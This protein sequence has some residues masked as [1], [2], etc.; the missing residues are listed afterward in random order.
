MSTARDTLSELARQAEPIS[1]LASS[2]MVTRAKDGITTLVRK[3]PASSVLGA[4][5]VGFAL[6]RLFRFL[7]EE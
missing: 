2:E 7:S 1:R 5:A 3:H 4:F 6:A